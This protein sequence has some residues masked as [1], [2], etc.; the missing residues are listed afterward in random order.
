MAKR[1]I[2]KDLGPYKDWMEVRRWNFTLC[3]DG[4][5]MRVEKEKVDGINLSH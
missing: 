4:G 1:Y 5:E 2:K 3:L